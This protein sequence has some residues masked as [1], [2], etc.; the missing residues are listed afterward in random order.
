M[1]T[2]LTPRRSRYAPTVVTRNDLLELLREDFT[3]ECRAIYAHAVFAERLKD[4]HREVAIHIERLGQETVRAA[5]TLCQLI[6]DYGGTVSHD[7]DELNAVLNA[8]RVATPEWEPESL[9]R[10]QA[11][12]GQLRA[13]GEPG[14][15]KR[16]R[17]IIAS[18][19]VNPSLCQLV[20]S[21]RE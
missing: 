2:K 18:K 8:D 6:Y 5:L 20:A 9:G 19:R 21:T 14:L 3:R 13:A 10:L 12:M 4:T 15:A 1:L 11:R 17:R 7:L 16:L